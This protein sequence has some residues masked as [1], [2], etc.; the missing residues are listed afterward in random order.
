MLIRLI[1][2][3]QAEIAILKAE[4]EAF[5][6]RLAATFQ[7]PTPALSSTADSDVGHASSVAHISDHGSDHGEES[8]VVEYHLE[9]G[10]LAQLGLY[11]RMR[12]QR[13]DQG[14]SPIRLADIERH[15]HSDNTRK[16]KKDRPSDD[17]RGEVMDMFE[18]LAQEIRDLK[19][20]KK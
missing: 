8:E 6:A 19:A 17:F 7:P 5:N 4:V 12:Q 2:E 1:K 20:T 13:V 3:Q 9:E 15:E 11:H 10:S 18:M 16:P 14:Y